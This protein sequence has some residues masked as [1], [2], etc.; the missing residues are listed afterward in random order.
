MKPLSEKGITRQ[1]LSEQELLEQAAHWFIA[2]QENPNC[3]N[4]Q[5]ALKRWLISSVHQAAW[6]KICQV[7]AFFSP[8]NQ[9]MPSSLA[10]KTLLTSSS[11]AN[12]NINRRGAMKGLFSLAIAGVL[13][14]QA[15]P[16]VNKRWQY[17]QADYNTAIG[18]MNDFLLADGSQLWLNTDSAVNAAF[19]NTTRQLTL[20]QGEIAI[21]TANSF[22]VTGH[23]VNNHA[24]NRY[25]K[26][27]RRFIV[28]TQSEQRPVIIEALGTQFTVRKTAQ[29]ITVNVQSGQVALSTGNQRY[30]INQG[31][32][33]SY[34]H[35]TGGTLSALNKT[36][37]DWQQGKFRAY[38]LPL[39]DLCQELARYSHTL[40]TL[41]DD[42]RQLKVVGTFPIVDIE[43]SMQ[44]LA[45]SLPIKLKQRTKW[46][47]LL[48]AK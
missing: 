27:Q 39:A 38:S 8:I 5:Q 34:H 15:Y 18:E 2:Q 48:S 20:L 12:R 44:L 13:T 10:T 43:Q 7:D 23:A 45:A 28:N 16:W 19:S 1:T 47:W 9:Q 33:L 37:N 46:W 17:V 42:I 25:V 26:D 3:S 30:L 32:Q 22:A 11:N 35:Q 31:Q 14:W 24:V 6:Q 36:V 41:D 40:I 21:T 29:Q 4:Q